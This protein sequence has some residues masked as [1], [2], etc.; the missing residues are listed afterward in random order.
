[1]TTTPMT[2]ASTSSSVIGNVEAYN[3]TLTPAG[4]YFLS[5]HTAAPGTTG[6]NELVSATYL[7][8]PVTFGPAPSGSTV[9]V[10][11]SVVVFSQLGAQPAGFWLG[12]WENQTGPG[13]LVGTAAV[14]SGAV[15]SNQ[16][17]QFAVGTIQFSGGVLTVPTAPLPLT[18][19]ISGTIYGTVPYGT[20]YYG[21]PP[22]FPV[23]TT[24]TYPATSATPT[25]T[26]V[27]AASPVIT[28]TLG[29][30]I[31][32]VTSSQPSAVAVSQSTTLYTLVNLG[33]NVPS[34]NNNLTMQL[35]RNSTGIP[36]NHNDGVILPAPATCAGL[37]YFVD[38]QLTPNSQGQFLYYSLFIEDASGNWWRVTDWQVML[39][40]KYD[41]GPW[42]F[43]L[44][45]EYYRNMDATNIL[46]VDIYG[47]PTQ[48][49]PIVTTPTP[50]G[51]TPPVTGEGRYD[52]ADYDEAI[53][54]P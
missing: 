50:I 3:G 14:V 30:T 45:P 39:P 37:S 38:R 48:G 9:Q 19:P 52:S 18:N 31:S 25:T 13:Y 1:M 23:I 44:L 27:P 6:A 11:T 28:P 29:F 24:P 10:N 35:I 40:F 51:P 47:L 43:S 20:S 53:Y 26:V 12:L 32:A 17:L 42:M 46:G 22:P 7:R 34:V 15:L 21:A 33:W 2:G 41:Y 16:S 49:N 5:L 8:Q 54:G 4:V 36:S